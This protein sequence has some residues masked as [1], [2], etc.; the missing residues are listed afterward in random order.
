M[1]TFLAQVFPGDITASVADTILMLALKSGKV[2]KAGF[3]LE[4]TGTDGA[5]PLELE[6]DVKIGATSIFSTLPKITKDAA[7]AS[8]SFWAGAGITVGVLDGVNSFFSE[9]DILNIVFTLTRTPAPGDEMAGAIAYMEY[10]E[11]DPTESDDSNE[12]TVDVP[13]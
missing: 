9:A 12:L 1:D 10:Q 13:V 7:D 5:N 8:S 3:Y 6:M 11:G 4:N 2:I